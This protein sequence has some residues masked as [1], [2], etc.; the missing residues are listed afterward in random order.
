M[1]AMIILKN[2]L[3]KPF[4]IIFAS[5]VFISCN[6]DNSTNQKSETEQSE[7][8]DSGD[9]LTVQEAF[10]STLVQDMLNEDE[11]VDLQIYLEEQIYPIVSKSNKVT[12]DRISSSIYLLSYDDNGVM[13]NI[14]IQK[15]YSPV[16]DEIFFEKSEILNDSLKQFLK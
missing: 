4:I 3:Y 11:E 14:S 16:K 9:S 2:I 10:S 8:D 15:Y 7:N 6:K 5:F 12:I 13:K 1:Y